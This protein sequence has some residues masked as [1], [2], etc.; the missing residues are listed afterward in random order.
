VYKRQNYFSVKANFLSFGYLILTNLLIFG[1]DIV[2]FLGISPESGN[3]FFTSNFWTTHPHLHTFL[4]V[5]QA[6]TLGLELTFYLV[7]PFILRK[8]MKLVVP[9]IVFSLLLRLYLFNY[10]GFRN[11]PWTYRFFPTEIMFFLLGFL[12]YRLHFRFKSLPAWVPIFALSVVVA[13]TLAYEQIPQTRIDYF[14]FTVKELAY[15]TLV[16]FSIPLLFNFFR[17]SK[18]DN[19]IGE[20]SYPVYISHILVFMVCNGLPFLPLKA[21]WVVASMTIMVAFF[22]NRYIASPFEQFRQARVLA[23]PQVN[24]RA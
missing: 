15:F 17:K 20:L 3:L 14:P 6:W 24:A 8:G 9:L 19:R 4:L 11:D 5:P 16:V 1:Q 10:L 12:A 13:F 23:V 7:A 22:L 21:G 18:L 2:M